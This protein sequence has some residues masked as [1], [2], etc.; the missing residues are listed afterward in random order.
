MMFKRIKLARGKPVAFKPLLLHTCANIFL[1]HFAGKRYDYSDS[2]FDKMT[3]YFD[4]IFYEVNQGRACD[5]MPWMKSLFY[6]RLF[7]EIR[8]WPEHIH[9]I[10]KPMVDERFEQWNPDKDSHDYIDALIETI[11]R[12]HD[13]EMNRE[14]AI[15]S[16]G[17]II[18]GHSA[19][20][21]FLMKVFAFIATR[22]QVQGRIKEEIHA[23]TNGVRSVALADR[24]LMPYTESVILE[25]MRLISS[26]IVPH[27]ASQDSSVAGR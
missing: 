9:D 2:S 22:P 18:G 24:K 1:L 16:L 13:T 19:I 3:Y 26:P 17:D 25:T 8:K 5:F 14:I 23:I 12:E 15:H 20:G 7:N 6:G 21:N 10:V 11:R 4:Q 27:V